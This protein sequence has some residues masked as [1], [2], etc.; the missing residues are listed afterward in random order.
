MSQAKTHSFR[1]LLLT[2]MIL[3]DLNHDCSVNSVIIDNQKPVMI[4]SANKYKKIALETNTEVYDMKLNLLKIKINKFKEMKQRIMEYKGSKD[5]M[6]MVSNTDIVQLTVDDGEID[7]YIKDSLCVNTVKSMV[8]VPKIN[9]TDSEKDCVSIHK[10]YGENYYEQYNKIINGNEYNN[11]IIDFSMNK[12]KNKTKCKLE[13]LKPTANHGIS[14][15]LDLFL[16]SKYSLFCFIFIRA[17]KYIHYGKCQ[18]KRHFIRNKNDINI[19]N[20]EII[21]KQFE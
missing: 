18:I 5:T 8:S 13:K 10:L 15:T 14:V 2:S 4:V 9:I 7:E 20:K 19:L 11:E 21:N 6:N 12:N 16:L 3:Y 1:C 17:N